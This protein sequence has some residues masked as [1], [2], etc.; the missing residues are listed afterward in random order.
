MLFKSSLLFLAAA[1]GAVAQVRFFGALPSRQ[2]SITDLTSQ[3]EPAEAPP[4][5]NA[6]AELKADVKV[7]FPDADILGLRLI[8][9]KPTR[10]VVDI[11]N[12]E[13]GPISVAFV[14]GALSNPEVLPEG[15]PAYQSIVRNLTAVQYNAAIEVGET[16]SLSYAFAQ[17]LHPQD[18]RL[19]ILA[20]VTND[21][22]GLFQVPA[23]DAIAAVVEP[24][25][26]FFDPQM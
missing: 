18:V 21:K 15:T 19:Q 9:G 17:D 1:I 20:V 26:S 7:T 24:P 10:A 12:K 14:A 3:D 4:V 25:T 11:T 8:N 16:K 23:Y 6:P 13:D 2:P 22:G 5:V